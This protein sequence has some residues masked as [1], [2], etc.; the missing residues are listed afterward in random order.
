MQELTRRRLR[1]LDGLRGFE[2]R[3]VEFEP[4]SNGR[5]REQR[6]RRPKATA[7]ADLKQIDTKDSMVDKSDRTVIRVSLPSLKPGVYGVE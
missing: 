2:P 6:P 3:C 7:H 5:I 1:S 4:V